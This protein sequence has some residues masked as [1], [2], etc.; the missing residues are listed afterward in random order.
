MLALMLAGCGSG[1]AAPGTVHRADGVRYILP[2]GWHAATRSLTPH[3]VNPREVFT[4]GT[5]PLA[6]GS[7][8]CGAI[9][10]N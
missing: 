6:T 1:H 5:G 9:T 8:R 4:A 7:G 10:R 3:L 2:A